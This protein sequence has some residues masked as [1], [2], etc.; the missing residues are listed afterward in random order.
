M[1]ASFAAPSDLIEEFQTLLHIFQ[2]QFVFTGDF[3]ETLVIV[4]AY[5][6][7]YRGLH[8]IAKEKAV[9]SSLKQN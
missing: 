3:R 6:D 1:P 9:L 8:S 2:V 7:L 5:Q 4:R